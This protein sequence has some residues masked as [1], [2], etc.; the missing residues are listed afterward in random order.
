MANLAKWFHVIRAMALSPSQA[1]AL[2]AAR[3]RYLATLDAAS[4]DRADLKA[5]LEATEPCR[6]TFG[7]RSLR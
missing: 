6:D 2:V 5:K 3:N 4:R 7:A 1:D